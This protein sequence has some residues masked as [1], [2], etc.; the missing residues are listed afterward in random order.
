MSMLKQDIIWSPSFRYHTNSEWEPAGFFSDSLCNSTSFDLMLGFFSSAAINVLAY[1]FATFLYN[2]GKMRMII[3]DILS[4]SDVAAISM[5][6]EQGELPYFDISDIDA[7]C[8]TLNKRDRHFFDC[9]A[10][11]IRNDRIEIKIVRMINGA[12]I[13]HTKCG[14]FFD[15][16]NKVGFDGSV[17]FS[18]SALIHNKE[19]LGV[20]CDWN[21]CADQARVEDLQRCFD[22][23]FK[24]E[25]DDLE[26]IDASSIKTYILDIC[27]PKTLS[28]LL[29]NE[30]ELIENTDN[31]AFPESVKKA[32]ASAK[33]SIQGIIENLTEQKHV[34][35]NTPQFPY[36]SGPREY[37][38]TAFENWRANNQRGL[39]AMATG[40]GKTI[41]SLNCLLEIYKRCGYY[42][43]IIL[44]PTIT[45]VN[46]WAQEC[47]KFRFLRIVK[48]CSKNPKWRKEID[49]LEFLESIDATGRQN[50]YIIIST[51][52]SYARDSVFNRL[53]I[54]PKK[55]L[56]LI[57]DEAHNIGAG[58]IMVRLT[59][60]PYLRRIG[61]SATPERQ[62]DSEATQKIMQFFGCE[63]GYTFE[64]SMA[65]AIDN[66]VLCRYKYYPHIVK[67]T[68]AEMEE[69]LDISRKLVKY[70]M[71]NQDA[72][73]PKDDAILTALLLKRKRII[74]K[75]ANKLP[76]FQE[77]LSQRLADKGTISYTLVYVPEGNKPD[78]D[79]DVFDAV[80]IVDDDCDSSHL[81]DLYTQI[82]RDLS[83][84][85]TVKQFTSE[86][87]ERDSILRDFAEGKLDIL[88]SMKC[89]D[90]GIDVPR[91]EMAIF[92]AS[93][94]NP[95]Q[96]I[97]RRGRILRKHPDKYMAEIHDLIVTPEICDSE[98]TY[99]ME[100]NMLANE[101]KRVYNFA[102]LSEN[103]DDTIREMEN[104][105]NYYNL[106]IFNI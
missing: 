27:K 57:A 101:L 49:D 9:L 76:I 35:D 3:N 91:S 80:D 34:I 95:R 12:G 37:Q 82:V 47:R 59:N 96:F 78:E 102:A 66:G 23:A 13:A 20:Y 90:E 21:G 99:K 85:T 70:Y 79:A 100:R 89:L 43:A 61:L 15:G 56:L 24:G 73:R 83:P 4:S 14:T 36:K 55:Q 10:W 64:Y 8:R 63:K 105:L 39:F 41:T 1:G 103:L 31:S 5:A 51:Y 19:S 48:V 25:D 68:T 81:I 18:L 2:G 28:E 97:Q 94:G 44:V 72:F 67:L 62:Y 65:E 38:Q 84:D 87:I 6:C 7:L 50:S 77:I 93:T 74:H 54:F 11:L 106:S 60:I 40:T 92:C 86:T 98:E 29:Y 42:K 52:A 17:N 104:T 32:L 69:Y 16:I 30:L 71:F 22:K 46:Q 53:N 26:F 88:T 33:K 45:L 58:K 75:A